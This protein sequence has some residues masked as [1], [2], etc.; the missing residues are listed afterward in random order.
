[1]TEVDFTEFRIKPHGCATGNDHCALP[2]APQGARGDEIEHLVAHLSHGFAKL[3]PT[4][5]IESDVRASVE[6]DTRLP[7]GFSMANHHDPTQQRHVLSS[8][9]AG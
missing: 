4:L 9:Q 1:V 8:I 6:A 7:L 2:G 3:S 5:I